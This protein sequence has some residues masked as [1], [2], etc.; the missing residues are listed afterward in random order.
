M[1]SVPVT[2]NHQNIRLRCLVHDFSFTDIF[3]DINYG[4]RALYWRKN[5]CGCF[6]FLWLGLVTMQMCVE[7][8]ALQLH[9]TSLSSSVVISVLLH[10]FQFLLALLFS[11]ILFYMFHSQ[12]NLILHFWKLWFVKTLTNTTFKYYY[13]NF[14]PVK[15]G[16]F[17]PDICLY[18]CAYFLG[19]LCKLC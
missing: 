10:Y 5:I 11:Y 12:W 4:Y 1:Y 14:I 19:F 3:N 13:S 18:L 6:R 8:C 2:Q 16:S 15:Q 7:R 17:P 9:H